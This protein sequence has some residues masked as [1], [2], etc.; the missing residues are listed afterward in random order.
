M[1]ILIGGITN[2]DIKKNRYIIKRAG[3]FI[4]Y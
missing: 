2:T 1:E 3:F 4:S